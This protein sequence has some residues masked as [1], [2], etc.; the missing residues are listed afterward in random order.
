MMVLHLMIVSKDLRDCWFI[1]AL[2]VLAIKDELIRGGRA[3]LEYDTD[4]IVD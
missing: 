2:S 4:M 3:G 1:S